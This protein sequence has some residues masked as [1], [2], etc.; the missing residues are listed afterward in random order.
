M[1]TQRAFF[2]FCSLLGLTI[3]I[4]IFWREL[5]MI[6]TVSSAN[7]VYCYWSG[8]SGIMELGQGEWDEQMLIPSRCIFFHETSCSLPNL[9]PQQ[10]C[11][12]ESA[13]RNNR[14]LNVFLLFL[15]TGQFSE[16]SK[17]IVD[18]L[19]TYDNVYIRR[20]R[21]STY[22]I[23]TPIKD[24]FWANIRRLW[25]NYDWLRN[26]F[27]DYIRMLTL[28]R[29]GGVSLNLNSIV[30]TPLD[31]LT[32]FVGVQDNRDM[33]VGVF[34][35]DTSTTFGRSFADACMEVIEDI[36]AD[37]Y[38]RYNITRVVT[39]AVWK[40]CYQRNVNRL[41]RDKECRRF[42]IYPPEKFYPA[43]SALQKV[44]PNET[45]TAEML[46]LRMPIGKNA[47]TIHYS[48]NNS[49]DYTRDEDVDGVGDDAEADNTAAYKMAA[50]QHCP[51]IYEFAG[52]SSLSSRYWITNT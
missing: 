38:L 26:D 33:G 7:H 32:T 43:S 19:Q 21:L 3:I 40:L 30:L 14:N 49:N 13:A 4:W 23:N 29:F 44:R 18:I 27:H 15:A 48:W 10:A 6:L 20:I 41:S 39:E 24:W 8:S 42:T 9:T 45:R 11:A 2:I 17:G 50:R 47:M 5:S 46:K 25:E 12:V 31:E 52:E 34:G 28:W 22:I 37:S 16:R 1:R 51:K 36:N 35:V